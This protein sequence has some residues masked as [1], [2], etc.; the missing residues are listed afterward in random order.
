MKKSVCLLILFVL[1]ISE[2]CISEINSDYGKIYQ[3]PNPETTF[4]SD[5]ITQLDNGFLV[6]TGIRNSYIP[7]VEVYASNGLPF[8]KWD[9]PFDKKISD[10]LYP[11]AVAYGNEV[12]LFLNDRLEFFLLDG[13]Y[14][15]TENFVN[16]IVSDPSRKILDM[17]FNKHENQIHFLVKYDWQDPLFW[18][19]YSTN[20][21]LIT[22]EKWTET[23]ATD[24]VFLTCIDEETL[25][26]NMLNCS[27]SLFHKDGSSFND[28]QTN[29]I[30][31]KI[32]DLLKILFG[33]EINFCISDIEFAESNIWIQS[34]MG[35][36][37]FDL[38]GKMKHAPLQFGTKLNCNIS[39]RLN[40]DTFFCLINDN[41]F[42]A[43]HSSGK[44]AGR[45][46]FRQYIKNCDKLISIT[47]DSSNN[48]WT[49][50]QDYSEGTTQSFLAKQSVE[51]IEL[52]K[53][54]IDNEEIPTVFA[55]DYQN[56]I[57]LIGK[58]KVYPLSYFGTSV[59]NPLPWAHNITSNVNDKIAAV[60]DKN[61][62]IYLLNSTTK[63]NV[64]V[65][66]LTG[67][68]VRTYDINASS[69][70]P[71]K[72]G[73]VIALF[74][75]QNFRFYLRNLYE[76]GSVSVS[77]QI[78]KKGNWTEKPVSLAQL[79]SGVIV[80]GLK[81]QIVFCAPIQKNKIYLSDNLEIKVSP[82]GT[83]IAVDYNSE[84]NSLSLY[85]LDWQKKSLGTS[86]KKLS[87]Y[88]KKLSQKTGNLKLRKKIFKKIF[89][90][91]N[92]KKS[93]VNLVFKNT[94]DS[95][96]A[97]NINAYLAA[98]HFKIS[99]INLESLIAKTGEKF[100]SLGKLTFSKS[101]NCKIECSS[102]RK[103]N[104]KGD[105]SGYI[106]TWFGD[107]DSII[108]K[109][110]IINSSFLSR[111]NIRKLISGKNISHLTVRAGISPLGFSGFSGDIN[112]VSSGENIENCTFIACA[113]EGNTPGWS[114]DA[115]EKFE[116]SI[117]NIRSKIIKAK[118]KF[119]PIGEVRNSLFV[120]KNPIDLLI[121]K[122]E[123]TTIIINGEKQ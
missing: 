79:E 111:R 52:N 120:S 7:F 35:L 112:Y 42:A 96:I 72:T 104:V 41:D 13:E 116:G 32:Y 43:F 86:Y 122:K 103:I 71:S 69:L 92:E 11:M 64:H 10:C 102:L 27:V 39:G 67:N 105:F 5:K 51:G 101:S 48:W 56:P 53:W 110:E 88:G 84:L 82:R 94:G 58:K 75:K 31:N 47:Q 77:Y 38:N 114:N 8:A 91:I 44:Q 25:F 22:S 36:F 29:E 3:Y 6:K 33:E 18:F 19:V 63:D 95:Q 26:G 60:A 4:L 54:N 87:H 98:R 14:L 20:G 89:K 118:N 37:C 50:Y 66:S 93:K 15:R 119:L 115:I 34:N 90:F 78:K 70:F 9:L 62:L 106:K 30:L 85:G 61:D 107:I 73:S 28:Y 81:N 80:V 109:G 117:F 108:I 123:E 2:S 83:P 65:F 100:S 24:S 23:T 16:S 76:D 40:D 46:F 74:L 57:A 21:T 1:L 45:W 12:C 68:Y 121:Q 55:C 97:L 99:G 17:S 113:T 49:V 59:E